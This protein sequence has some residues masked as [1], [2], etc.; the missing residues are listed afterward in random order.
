MSNREASNDRDNAPP[1]EGGSVSMARLLTGRI[2][3]RCNCATVQL[4]IHN[5][6][7]VYISV[8]NDIIFYISFFVF[9]GLYELVVRQQ[10][11][12]TRT[13]DL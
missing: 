6:V 10:L 8:D 9:W 4:S 3:I 13:H 11:Y 5:M 1:N 12:L 7:R 2:Y